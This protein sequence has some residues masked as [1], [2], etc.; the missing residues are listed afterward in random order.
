MALNANSRPLWAV[1]HLF[2]N[3]G[4]QTIF[5][6]ADFSIHENEHVAL[7]GRNG[8][9]KS[10]LLRIIAGEFANVRGDI[11]IANN[12]RIGYLPHNFAVD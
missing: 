11:A 5:E 3:I 2:L 1:R 12:I 10:T 9:G 6:D 7:V 8:C 4:L